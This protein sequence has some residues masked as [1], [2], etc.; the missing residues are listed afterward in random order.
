MIENSTI[1]PDKQPENSELSQQTTTDNQEFASD[2]ISEPESQNQVEPFIA[3]TTEEIGSESPDH[4]GESSIE[5][6]DNKDMA[7]SNNGEASDEEKAVLSIVSE[8]EAVEPLE[9]IKETAEMASIVES[10]SD[11]SEIE[12]MGSDG[13]ES[14]A[15]VQS[16][17][18]EHNPVE[19]LADSREIIPESKPDE[20]VFSS[21]EMH[22]EAIE[23]VEDHELEAMEKE[24]NEAE[25]GDFS[26]LDKEQLVKLV[27]QLN[28]DS[29][30]EIAHRSI[31]K[32]KPL[33]ETLYHQELNEAKEKYLAEGG[34]EDTFE[35]KYA[36]LLDRF[37]QAV[38]GI[39]DRRKINLKIQ[40][41]ERSKNLEAKLILLDQLRQ[42][43]GD[44]EHNPGYEKFKEIREEWKKIGPVGSEHVKNLNDSYYS[45][46][47][48]FH[49]LSEIFHNLRDF[50][51]KKNLEQKLEIISKIEKLADEPKISK[52]LMDLM[53]YQSEFRSL[54]P[55]PKEKVEELRDRFKAAIDIIY[56]RRK[57]FNEERKGFLQ[58][59]IALKEALVEKIAGFENFQSDAVRDWQSKTKEILALQEEWKQIPNRFREKTAELNKQFWGTFKKFI[60][61]KNEFFKT[62]EKGRKEI[63]AQ[64]QAL[65]DEVENLKDGED[66]DGIANRMKELQQDWKKIAPVF[67]KEGQKIYEAFKAGIDHFFSR[68]RDQKTGEE[69][70][71]VGNLTLKENICAEIEALAQSG[72]ADRQQVE[73]LRE[74]FRGVGF[75][76][77]KSIQKI[78][79]R[80]SKAMID[81]IEAAKGISE[82]EKEKLKISLLSSRATFSSE[83]V[84][85]LRNQE[86]YIQKRLQQLKKDVNNLEDNMAMFKMSKNA[87]AII[88]DYQKRINLS[89]LEIKEL[90]S[91]LRDIRQSE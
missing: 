3:K 52:A 48:Q 7:D 29:N 66:F 13:V 59:E 87:M 85:S 37:H 61:N 75:V 68:L 12:S 22:P 14:I 57:A 55:V 16:E 1:S 67:G 45:L 84:K 18:P 30:P 23:L 15:E 88:E 42:L 63:L 60:H 8:Q 90:E 71:Q 5:K 72:E 83:G 32:I 54:G 24:E 74:K 33:F 28:R 40:G 26:G 36:P 19:N 80:F 27:E 69:K 73:A 41:E 39:N 53:N 44:H 38:K 62:L 43:V 77:M 25:M 10:D 34:T 46:I 81:M 31:Q 17:E 47:E 58:E 89:R 20:L 65:V 6:E 76:P 35:F 82:N 91:Q 86:G 2:S 79:A 70:V 4:E 11:F 56:S 51:R 9:G 78:N 64:K 21:A 50:D 49:S